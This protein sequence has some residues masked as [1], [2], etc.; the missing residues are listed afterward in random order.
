MILA[1]N[2]L[3]DS[4]SDTGLGSCTSRRSGRITSGKQL[5]LV[6]SYLCMPWP[7]LFMKRLKEA[8]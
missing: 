6:L 2:I 4:V 7:G 8:V 5:R 3:I 1:T